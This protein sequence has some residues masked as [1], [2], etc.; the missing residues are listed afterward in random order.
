VAHEQV[1]LSGLNA[2]LGAHG[3]P[4][5]TDSIWTVGRWP[6]GD[7]QDGFR[8]AGLVAGGHIFAESGGKQVRLTLV[9][10]GLRL[11][12][13]R[14]LAPRLSLSLGTAAAVGGS[15]LT[16][17]HADPSSLGAGLDAGYDTTF[18]R[19][20]VAVVPDAALTADL[21]GRLRLHGGV[22][23]RIDT[24][25]LGEWRTASGRRLTDG[26]VDPLNGLQVRLAVAWD[27]T[28]ESAKERSELKQR[29][30]DLERELEETR[31]RL[32][33]QIEELSEAYLGVSVSDVGLWR[34][35]ILGLR[36]AYVNAVDPGSPAQ[37]AGLRPGD[38]ILALGGLTIENSDALIWMIQRKR[39]GE[40]VSIEVRRDGRTLF[41]AAQLG[42]RPKR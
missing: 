14:V 1:V 34:R 32:Q 38:I 2:E 18:Y 40:W 13:E 12:Y 29:V 7:F 28:G 27:S 9:Y 22:A 21:G 25:L 20:F 5:L 37:K 31:R 39:P 16:V 6:A 10:G 35:W 15:V 24:S 17:I 30:E 19:P 33:S 3:L 26:P 36:G 42:R 41:L 11:G 23:Y 4:V 8:V